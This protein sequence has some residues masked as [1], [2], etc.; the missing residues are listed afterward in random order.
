MQW[1]NGCVRCDL[2]VATEGD[3]THG[4]HAGVVVVAVVRQPFVAS[5]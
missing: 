5:D 1:L 2:A 4:R 3:C